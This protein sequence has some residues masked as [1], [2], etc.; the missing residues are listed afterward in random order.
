[1]SV[2]SGM[3][4]DG[5]EDNNEKTINDVKPATDEEV[6]RLHAYIKNAKPEW[7]FDIDAKTLQSLLLRIEK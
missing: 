7:K 5:D 6:E 1:M 3:E 4:W 2:E